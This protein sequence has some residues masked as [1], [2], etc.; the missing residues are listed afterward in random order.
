MLKKLLLISLIVIVVVALGLGAVGYAYAQEND[1][2]DGTATPSWGW[3]GGGMGKHG[4]M[5]GHAGGRAGPLHEYMLTA[6]AEGLEMA[7]EA[8]QARL[9]AGETPYQVA[10]AAGLSEEQ[11]TALFDEAH[12]Q[13]LQAA[14]EAGALTQEQADW[15]AQRHQQMGEPG[16]GGCMSGGH[17]RR[18]GR[19]GWQTQP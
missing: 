2:T 13:A 10:Q 4:G 16:A 15:M 19:G 12:S 1:P 11:I 8:L 6:L 5:M 7:T 17:G 3:H 14:V 18:G 9:D